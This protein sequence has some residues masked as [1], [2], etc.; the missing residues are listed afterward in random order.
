MITPILL[1]GGVGT[2]LWPTSRKS[3][4]K[5]FG[6]LLGDH[7]LFQTTA[8]RFQADGFAPPLIVTGDDFR[9]IVTEQLA[10]CEIAAQSILLEPQARNTAPA[11][12]AAA[13]VLA[14]TDPEALILV[15]PS[16]HSIE[17]PDLF[18]QA[19]LKG[20]DA[21]RAGQI[22]TFGIRPTRAETGYGWLELSSDMPVEGG[23]HPLNR[24]VEK[25]DQATAEKLV[26]NPLYLWN[27]GVFLTSVQSLIKSFQTYSPNT[28]EAVRASVSARTLDLGF[29]RLGAENWAAS[30]AISI[31]YA[32]MEQADNLSVVPFEGAWSDLGSWDAVWQ[33]SEKD[34][35]GNALRGAA[36]AI[37]CTNTLLRAEMDDIEVVGIGLESIVAIAMRDAVL[38]ADMNRAQSV[39]LAVDHLKEHGAKQATAFPVDHRPWGWFETLVVAER[40]QVKRIHVHPGAS[41][42]LQK[43]LHRAEHWVV[44]KGTA[45]STI[46]GEERLISENESL[47]VPLAS[48]HR[49]QNPGKVPVVLIEVQTGSYLGEDDIMRLDDMYRR[50]A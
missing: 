37:D 40:F 14:E 17:A 29:T 39:K 26:Q 44:V 21:A 32:I 35:N 25:P 33:E 13:L 42:S 2:R 36:T 3:Y 7:S 18:R 50:N 8:L 16:D 6:A 45:L 22:V 43:H 15:A 19:V 20:V 11:V 28:L 49:L 27:A 34:C 1:C 30:P 47:F 9:F 31:D 10:A 46:N 41:L 4:P 48:E 24:F 12:L 5:Q 38:I 23:V